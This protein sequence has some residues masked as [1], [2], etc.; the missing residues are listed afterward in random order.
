MDMFS[1]E[2][3]K[4]SVKSRLCGITPSTKNLLNKFNKNMSIISKKLKIEIIAKTH[5]R[6]LS[7][8]IAS[9]KAF[10]FLD[11]NKKF[12]SLKFFTGEKDIIGLTKA[13]WIR[14]K[15]YCGSITFRI[16]DNRSLVKAFTFAK[17][18]CKIT[19]ETLEKH[20]KQK[21]ILED[22]SQNN[23]YVRHNYTIQQKL[24]NMDLHTTKQIICH[25]VSSTKW[26]WLHY[27]H[28]WDDID[29]I[30]IKHGYEQGGF[31]I[32]KII[33][34]F[35]T[36]GICSI[37]KLGDIL[38]N[39]V[40]P[41][42]Y[43]RNYAGALDSEF[44]TNLKFG[45]LGVSGLLFYECINIFLTNKVGA[46]GAFFWKLIWQLLNSC[47]FLRNKYNSSFSEY[48]RFKYARFIGL[49]DL[50]THQFLSISD[51]EWNLFLNKAKPWESLYGIGR[52]VF[53]FIFGDII[54]AQFVHAAYKFDSAN[55]Y[56]Y[57]VTGIADLIK[58]F[59]RNNTIQFLKTLNLSYNLR[60]I[61]KGIY[62]YCSKTEGMNFGFCRSKDKCIN[63]GVQNLCL[64]RFKG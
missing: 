59:E 62:T 6:G 26:R 8:F 12:L 34:L 15:D 36:K 17:L 1:I 61:N 54:E 19:L 44:Y 20:E 21:I 18:S 5:I 33:P 30:F 31:Q 7:Y 39:S 57:K 11:I 2:E 63:C 38:T 52:N 43:N 29:K 50:S 49:N 32:F 46:P 64:Q 40:A 41:K 60:E 24:V 37:N 13:N 55:Q 47:N 23:K 51:S 3:K 9:T 58:P 27:K 25:A 35:E 4:Y 45:N 16:N 22:T 56:F 42:K 53:D 10:I 48:I 14:G 28:S